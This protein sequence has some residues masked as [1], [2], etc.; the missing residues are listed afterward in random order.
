MFASRMQ[1]EVSRSRA[2]VDA[3][4]FA[5]CGYVELSSTRPVPAEVSGCTYWTQPSPD[6]PFPCVSR[7]LA[8]VATQSRINMGSRGCPCLGM[9][10]NDVRV[11]GL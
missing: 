9:V 7:E 6:R 10:C 1:A 3:Y 5:A 2:Y 4:R 11:S 8:L